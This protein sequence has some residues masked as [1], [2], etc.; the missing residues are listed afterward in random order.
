MIKRQE[1]EYERWRHEGAEGQQRETTP[2]RQTCAAAKQLEEL[3][4]HAERR[5]QDLPHH[6]RKRRIE[7][8]RQA[9][10]VIGSTDAPERFDA[11]PAPEAR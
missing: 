4:A 2:D 5:V 8:L 1:V 6:Q 3:F 11:W 9:R 7:R 10:A